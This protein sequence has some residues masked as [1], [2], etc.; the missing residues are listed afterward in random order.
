M[1]GTCWP[2]RWQ[3]QS[4]AAAEPYPPYGW[5]LRAQVSRDAPP[6]LPGGYTVGD[7]VFYTGANDTLP[8]GI[9]K[10]VHGQ[11]GEVT[12]PPNSETLKDK[13]VAVRFPGNMG[14]IA[15]SLTSVRRLRAA[16]AGS[17]MPK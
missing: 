10:L 2:L 6:P 12:G 9:N 7:K 13:C 3:R 14:S 16:P 11:Q 4:R 8:S 17:P 5:W 15:C 1:C